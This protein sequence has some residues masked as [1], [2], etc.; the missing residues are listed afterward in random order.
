MANSLPVGAGA[1][2]QFTIQLGP[3]EGGDPYRIPW[4]SRC[5]SWVWANRGCPPE[6]CDHRHRGDAAQHSEWVRGHTEGGAVDVHVGEERDPAVRN[7]GVGDR[8]DQRLR[9]SP[10]LQRTGDGEATL[11]HGPHV[12]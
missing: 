1:W 6:A 9:H 4:W 2:N 5:P 12:L 3:G 7:L 8:N 11:A 10:D